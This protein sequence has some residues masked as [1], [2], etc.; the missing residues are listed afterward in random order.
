MFWTDF[1]IRDFEDLV[2]DNICFKMEVSDGLTVQCN[3]LCLIS[4]R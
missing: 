3:W 2:L 4:Y 1:V